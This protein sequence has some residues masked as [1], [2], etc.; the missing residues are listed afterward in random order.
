MDLTDNHKT[1]IYYVGSKVAFVSVA[2]GD[3]K[4]KG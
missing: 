3:A 2:G 4:T 1:C